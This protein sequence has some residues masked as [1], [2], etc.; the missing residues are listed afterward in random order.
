MPGTRSDGAPVSTSAPLRR[1]SSITNKVRTSLASAAWWSTDAI[2]VYIGRRQIDTA[3]VVRCARK[4]SL[5]RA[6]SSRGASD[7]GGLV[8]NNVF[9]ESV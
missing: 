8:G 1:P 3:Y 6:A 7:V 2:P 9:N 4:R 5:S